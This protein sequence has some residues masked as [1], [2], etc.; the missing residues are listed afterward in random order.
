MHEF[1]LF[2]GKILAA[3]AV[4]LPAVSSAALYGRGIFTTAAIYRSR[5]FQWGKHWRRLIEN[6]KTVG[7]DLSNY[8]EKDVKDSLAEIIEQNA[9]ENGRARLTFFDESASG[10]WQFENDC[11]TSF[12]ITTANF[13][14][15][16]DDLRLSL[17][18]FPVN[19]KSPLSRVKSCN[20]LENLL[21]LDEV[22]ARGYDEA[23]R[24]NEKGEI[25]S[26][27]MA[28]IFW[29]RAGEIF[30]PALETGALDGTTRAFIVEHFPVREACAAIDEVTVA[31]EIFLASAG[32]GIRAV[33]GIDGRDY[34]RREIVTK[35][36]NLF[37]EY[38]RQN[39]V[40]GEIQS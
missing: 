27:A 30:T 24:I 38:T 6:S 8:S 28:N 9:I 12:L 1:L 26:A 15:V 35:I 22:K 3:S 37:D 39:A 36:K 16:S 4:T 21:V 11:R 20:Y 40:G 5:L 31:D 32:F 7:V 23:I 14:L 18:P 29:T 13:R 33:A 17:S 25:V 10:I 34:H 19:S 2:N